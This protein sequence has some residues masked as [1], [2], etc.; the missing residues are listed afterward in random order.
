DIESGELRLVAQNQGMGMLTD[1]SHNERYGIL[2][3]MQNRSDDNLFLVD[4]ASDQITLLTPHEGP[5]S[6]EKGKFSPDGQIIY[7]SSNKD[8]ELAALA[9]VRLGPGGEPGPI[10]VIAGRDDAELQDFEISEDG[11]VAALIWNVAGRN[12]LVFLD[13]AMLQL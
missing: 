9:R 3:R 11:T 12:E 13:L 4:F 10:E 7:L 6:F 8:R 2:Y 1:V 5:G